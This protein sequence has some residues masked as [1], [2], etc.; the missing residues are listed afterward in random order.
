MFTHTRISLLVL[1]LVFCACEKSA[2]D[3]LSAARASLAE[4]AFVQA[5]AAADSGLAGGPD[6]ITTWGLELVKLEAHARAGQGAETKAALTSLAERFPERISASDYS[7]TAQQLQSAEQGPAAIEL[8]DQG[9]KR[10]P[11]DALIVKMLEEA[12]S[13]GS[14]PA[15][16]DMLRSLGYI[17]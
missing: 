12:V 13:G 8:L 4:G 14:D 9:A 1:L 5:V 17:E 3:H 15:E 11:D 7:G 10:F 2:Q 6:A 16:L